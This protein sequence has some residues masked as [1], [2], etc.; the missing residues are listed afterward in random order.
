MT[1]ALPHTGLNSSRLIRLLAD[2]GADPAVA[3]APAAK[4]SFAERLG[5]WLNHIDAISLFAA[6]K[7]T[8][9]GA[10]SLAPAG[11]ASA[12]REEF[13][14]LRTALSNSITQDGTSQNR[15]AR[16]RWPTPDADIDGAADFSPYRRYYLA[17]Q[18]E[19]DASV[20]PLRAKARAALATRS[21]PLQRL[22]SLDAALDTALSDRERSVLANVPALLEKRYEQLRLAHQA[23]SAA[24]PAADD[25]QRWMQPGGWLAVFNK[26]MRDALLAELEVRLQPVT[27]LIEAFGNEVTP[28]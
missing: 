7:G 8:A 14:R 26:D 10:Q 1:R 3:D 6:L 18:R 17:H 5:L 24:T 28:H 21:A 19:M 13:A 12:L 9:G 22:A 4:Q 2:M 15:M 27:G 11:A 25:P 23:R 20:G 16:I